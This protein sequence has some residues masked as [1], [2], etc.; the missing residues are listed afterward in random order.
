M[1]W[2]LDGFWEVSIPV[3][4]LITHRG[5]RIQEKFDN[6]GM[7]PIDGNIKRS[8][9]YDIDARRHCTMEMLIDAMTGD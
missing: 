5:T 7:Q 2:L 8:P 1:A 9:W 4:A 6:V 3:P